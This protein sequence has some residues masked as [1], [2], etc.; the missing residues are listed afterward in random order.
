MSCLARIL[1]EDHVR[2]V[3]S[4]DAVCQCLMS[5]DP[6]VLHV[7]IRNVIS[8]PL[9]L[10]GSNSYHQIHFEIYIN[11]PWHLR[12]TTTSL[13]Y[14]HLFMTVISSETRATQRRA[15]SAT[16]IVKL[17]VNSTR[18]VLLLP[19][20]GI[21]PSQPESTTLVRDFIHSFK[22]LENYKSVHIQ[23]TT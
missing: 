8:T 17:K 2:C 19:P 3:V 12:F 13:S 16:G 14:S 15:S 6:R 9:S 4:G 1:S 11:R 5:K 23:L 18:T 10:F 22:E 20:L 7:E 21:V